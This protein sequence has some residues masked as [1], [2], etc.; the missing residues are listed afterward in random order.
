[1]T[2]RAKLLLSIVSVVAATTGGTLKIAQ[3]QARD[4]YRAMLD[5]LFRSEIASFETIQ[6]QQLEEARRQVE[7]LSASVRLFAALGEDDP[8]LIYDVAKVELRGAEFDFYRLANSEGRIFPAPV[9]AGAGDPGPGVEAALGAALASL[10]AG[11]GEGTHLGFLPTRAASGEAGGMIS[12]MSAAIIDANDQ[13][14]AGT[15]LLGKRLLQPRAAAGEAPLLSALHAGGEIAS[16]GVP[17]ALHAAL[18]TAISAHGGTP[19]PDWTIELGGASYRA[20]AH[21]LNPGS[22]FPPANLVS[23]YPLDPL[24][25]GQRALLWRVSGIAALGLLAAAAVGLLFAHRLSKPVLDL[26][27]GTS[28]IRRGNFDVQVRRRTGDELGTLADSFNEMAEGLRLKEKYRSVL[29]LVTDHEVAEELMT[30]A[31]QLGGEMREVSVIFCDVRG[32][33]AM[34][35]DMPPAEVVAMLN[36]HMSAL[37]HVVHEHRGV[38]DKFVGDSIM[39]LFGAP[40]SYG[41]DPESAVRCAWAMI[42]ARERLN[43][44]TGCKLRI[45]IGIASGPVLAGCM[46]SERRLDYTV[47]GERVNLAAR[48]C[49]AAGP[50]EIVIDETTRRQLPS[51]F[52]VCELEPLALKGFSDKV[53]ACRV[54]DVP[55]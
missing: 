28:E 50:M 6:Q 31:V 39:T 54:T 40:K 2:F 13:S 17:A 15:L 30:G 52:G 14:L 43:A 19:P 21:L 41:R 23:L 29:R 9:Q 42:R 47:I 38:V 34:S 44:A 36:E 5:G 4:T 11:G 55:A 32:F 27:K 24:L 12:V 25:R 1:M 48:L 33:T 22:I 8:E 53:T 18:K 10:K 26:V 16:H 35:Q 37:T 3:D 7:R 51:S 45:G 49:S 46:G 20:D